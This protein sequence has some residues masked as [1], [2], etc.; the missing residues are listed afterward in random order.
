MYTPGQAAQ[1]L[2]I[3]PSTLRRWANLVAPVL[4]AGARAAHAT[5]RGSARSYTDA[6]LAVLREIQTGLADSLSLNDIRARLVPDTHTSGTYQ[7]Y[8]A[9][10][11][12]PLDAPTGSEPSRELATVRALLAA[13][14]GLIANQQQHI[15][16]QQR[17]VESLERQVQQRDDE[18]DRLRAELERA[19]SEQAVLLADVRR[20]LGKIPRWLRALLGLGA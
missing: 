10:E 7:A 11:V 20:T 3:D 19:R 1:Q 17:I 15:E 9:Q 5:R 14:E 12:V 6:D 16:Q 18:A 2:G 8:D 13:H 4:S